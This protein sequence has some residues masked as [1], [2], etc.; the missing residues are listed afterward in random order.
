MDEL[1]VR[2]YPNVELGEGAELGLWV[3]VGEPPMGHSAGELPT[4]LGRNARIRSHTVVY[5][6]NAIGERFQT[7]HGVLIRESNRIGN[8][9][10]IG[11]H[12]IIEHHVQI[13]DG[14]RVHSNVFIP[15]YSVLEE[16]AWVGPSVTFTNAAYPRSPQAKANLR[17]PHLLAG[18]KIGAN[19]TLLPGVTIGKNALVGAGAVVVRDVPD[20]KVVVGNPARIVRDVADISAY[21]VASLL[22]EGSEAG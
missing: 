8:D 9:V 16:G 18:A 14:V 21:Q 15:E 22:G 19:A 11:S 7:G 17:G 20:G 5:A 2:V 6:G 1:Q 3:I 13:G 10:S 4:H 12:S